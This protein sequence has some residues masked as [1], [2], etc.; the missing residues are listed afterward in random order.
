ML[1][2]ALSRS[3]Y[4]KDEYGNENADVI[5]TLMTDDLIAKIDAANGAIPEMEETARFCLCETCAAAIRHRKI[6]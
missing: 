1:F 4:C 3:S 6:Y 5:E 2:G